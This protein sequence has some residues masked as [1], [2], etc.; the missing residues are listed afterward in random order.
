EG[1]F[2]TLAKTLELLRLTPRD[3][4]DPQGVRGQVNRVTL[5]SPSAPPA[6][7]PFTYRADNVTALVVPLPR[8]VRK[9]ESVT[10]ELE[11]VLD[12]PPKQ[13]RW[14]Q[15]PVHPDTQAALPETV[16]QLSSWMPVLAYYDD[17]GWHPTP[18]VPWHQPFF[19]EA[20]LFAA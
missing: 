10:V 1:D 19:N 3:A 14:G 17:S 20:G 15:W 11:Y 18:F 16:T 13:G 12:L 2:G 8:P 9:G 5:L 7:L 4:M 6:E